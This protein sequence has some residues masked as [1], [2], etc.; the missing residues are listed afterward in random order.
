MNKLVIDI[1]GTHI[2]C[3]IINKNYKIKNLIKNNS[4]AH[5]I[6]DI[7]KSV[8]HFSKKY[9][10]KDIGISIGGVIDNVKG[11]I[12]F[13]N[14][15]I[16][17]WKTCEIVKE[18]NL[19]FNNKYNIKIDN[20]GNCAALAEKY[21]GNAI[22][23]DNFVNLVLGTGVGIGCYINGKMIKYSEIGKFIEDKCSGK[24]FDIQ[25]RINNS[26]KMDK[27]YT[28]SAIFLGN[29]ILELIILLNPE[30]I[31][32][33]GPLIKIS[34]K[35]QNTIKNTISKNMPKYLNTKIIFSNMENQNLIG[36]SCLF[37]N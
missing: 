32:L 34:K 13:V 29:K 28:Q 24:Y 3:A 18:L 6:D 7:K 12:L 27:I 11:E 37:K 25:R 1:G 4:S 31:I 8:Q 20:D 19:Y 14:N 9:L 21:Y 30:K 2:R 16:G 22:N 10:F 5:V 15:K 23:C 36:V 26:D 33:N 17:S 35:F